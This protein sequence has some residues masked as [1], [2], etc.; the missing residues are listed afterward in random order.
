MK[1]LLA[2]CLAVALIFVLTSPVYAVG[3]KKNGTMQG[4]VTDIDLKGPAS[5]DSFDGSTLII[6]ESG[7]FSGV[8]TIVSSVSQL[9]SANLA[10]GLLKLSGATKTFSMVAGAYQGQEISL[11][12][13]E[14]DTRTLKLDFSIDNP[15]I[16]HTG[17]TSV[18][19]GTGTLIGNWVTLVW[20]DSTVGWIIT[21]QGTAVTVA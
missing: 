15:N 3:Y 21:G 8:S 12:K 18:T 9:S 13:A 16:A 17:F 1:K 4:A 11:Q 10:F 14:Y 6:Y 7:P 20:I 2:V 5:S 19:F